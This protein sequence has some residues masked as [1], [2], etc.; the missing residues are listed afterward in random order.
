M[1]DFGPLPSFAERRDEGSAAAAPD[2][3]G[4]ECEALILDLDGYEGPI[5]LLL[6]LARAQKLDLA[7]ISILSLADQYLEFIA[8]RRR[9]DLEVA[10]DYLVMAAV[11][12]YL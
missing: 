8:A 5:D 10:A 2:R 4:A 7:K 6:S 11:L 3:D 12:A 9:L 1:N